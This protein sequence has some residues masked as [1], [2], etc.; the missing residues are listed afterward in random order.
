MKQKIRSHFVLLFILTFGMVACSAKSDNTPSAGNASSKEKKASIILSFDP[1]KLAVGETV[2]VNVQIKNAPVIYG[3][4]VRLTFDP[5]VLEV[6]DADASQAGIQFAPGNFLDPKKSFIVQN[7]VNNEAGTIDYA[8][9]LL[10]P[11]PPVS[12]K[13]DLFQVTFRAK[14]QG[15]TT[16]SISEGM[17]GT[18]SGE[19]FNPDLSSAE[20]SISNKSN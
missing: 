15:K 8:L 20:I 1:K 13:G 10:N 12:G 4:D 6:V 17:F 19:T 2:M 7:N 14:T 3:S 9:S 16:I 11:A 18:Q 5:K